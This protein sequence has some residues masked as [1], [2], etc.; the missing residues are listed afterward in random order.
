M[1]VDV[2]IS[3][4][5]IYMFQQDEAQSCF[6]G[7]SSFLGLICCQIDLTIPYRVVREFGYRSGGSQSL[8]SGGPVLVCWLTSE[9]EKC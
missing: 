2:N 8:L 1:N 3:F 5:D 6:A 9:K 4:G 7:T